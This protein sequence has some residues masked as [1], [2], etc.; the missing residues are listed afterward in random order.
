MYFRIRTDLVRENPHHERKQRSARDNPID[1][2]L[3]ISSNK[4]AIIHV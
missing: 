3:H 4:T 2:G 1:T